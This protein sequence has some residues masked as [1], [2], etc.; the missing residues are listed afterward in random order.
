MRCGVLCQR[1]DTA[2]FFSSPARCVLNGLKHVQNPGF[3]V[4]VFC[5]RQKQSVIVGFVLNDVPTQ[6]QNRQLKQVLLN[7]K[8][9]V[10]DPPGS[11]IA[12]DKRVNCLKLVMGH[13]HANKRVNVLLMM[14][15]PFPVRQHVT[16]QSFALGRR[17][18]D[19]SGAVVDQLRA[20]CLADVH[21]H[22]FECSANLHSGSGTQRALFD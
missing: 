15:K 6:I 16:Q 22:R 21:V 4:V 3:P 17:V 11:A 20:R 13:R 8:K 2:D 1:S 5:H 9:Y 12:V 19:V 14:D 18:N 7:Q 10:D